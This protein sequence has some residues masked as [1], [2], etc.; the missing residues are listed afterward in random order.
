MVKRGILLIILML[1]SSIV[2]AVDLYDGTPDTDTDGLDDDWETNYFGDLSSTTSADP[3]SDGLTNLEEYQGWYAQWADV[4]G[5][6]TQLKVYSDPSDDDS[7]DDGVLD[8]IENKWSMNPGSTDTDSDSQLD[9]TMATTEARGG[10]YIP[11]DPCSTTANDLTYSTRTAD[12][13]EAAVCDG[14][15]FNN[16][17]PGYINGIKRLSS[18]FSAI[19]DSDDVCTILSASSTDEEVIRRELM[20]FLLNVFASNICYTREIPKISSRCITITADTMEELVNSAENAILIAETGDYTTLSSQM[21]SINSDLCRTPSSTNDPNQRGTPESEAS[22]E[23]IQLVSSQTLVLY[24]GEDISTPVVIFNDGTT[25]L[26]DL[27]VSATSESGNLIIDVDPDFIE[28]LLPGESFI[29]TLNIRQSGNKE[30]NQEAS[31]SGEPDQE[32][33]T[34]EAVSPTLTIRQTFTIDYLP[35]NEPEATVEDISDLRA[36]LE[37]AK[38]MFKDNPS[39]LRFNNLLQQAEKALDSSKYLKTSSLLDSSISACSDLITMEEKYN[40]LQGI[41]PS[42]R[43]NIQKLLSL[44]SPN[45]LWILIVI[46]LALSIKAINKK[47]ES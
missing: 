31:G 45:L 23:S 17:M 10:E 22:A 24:I 36:K 2:F 37:Q 4:N 14:Q 21:F 13:W 46:A 16:M 43:P 7:D 28:E 35:G 39:C 33:I 12:I 44:L 5:I 26:N 11:T 40:L 25:I 27:E 15:T 34:I 1:F 42:D 41:N 18:V 6:K 3:D 47:K 30:P 20:S 19:E 29:P 8:N 32:I 9:Y 38:K